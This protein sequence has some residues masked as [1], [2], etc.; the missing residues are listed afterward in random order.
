MNTVKSPLKVSMGS[1]G[2]EHWTAENLKWRE[3]DTD[4]TDSRS[5]KLNIKWG[6]PLNWWT[7]NG[8]ST[9]LNWKL[10][11]KIMELGGQCL[12]QRNL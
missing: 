8:S 9:V 11:R 3:F 7:L 10:T 6:K 5:L 12:I 4:T 2:S 1:C